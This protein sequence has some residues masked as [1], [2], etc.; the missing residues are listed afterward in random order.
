MQWAK[1]NVFQ[2]LTR[3]WDTIHPYNAAQA[4]RLAGALDAD[5]LVR[6]WESAMQSMGVGRVRFAGKWF[7]HEAPNGCAAPPPPVAASNLQTHVTAELNRPFHASFPLSPF[8]VADAN[9]PVVGVAY[10]HWIAD[11]A[12]IRVLLREWF[13]R[14]QDPSR[15]NST[16]GAFATDGYRRHVGPTFGR[17]DYFDSALTTLRWSMRL[18]KA[19][20]VESPQFAQLA[21]R[22][23]LHHLPNGIVHELLS[24]A[25][26][27]SATLND[28][29]LAVVAQVCNDLSPVKQT[30]RR[31]D[32]ALGTIVD[33]RSRDRA[34]LAD[35]FGLFLG[36]TSVVCRDREIGDW[37]SLLRTIAR[38]NVHH[39]RTAAAEASM[40]R[41]AAGLGLARIYSRQNLLNWYR[42][43]VPLAGG[44]S[45]VNM[46]R[47]WPAEF[48]PDPILEY[49][50]V[51]PCGP[52]MPLVFTTTTLGERLNFGLTCRRSVVPLELQHAIAGAFT[53]RLVEIARRGS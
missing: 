12:S 35:S 34:E 45:N 5:R 3:Q 23:T 51:S 31:P 24:V 43:R 27:G 47:D 42:K 29:F 18:R 38:Q 1:F 37:P 46:N 26:A 48:H 53:N 8:F 50:R 17:W 10:H 36:F 6:A 19:R 21:T 2:R 11:S 4:M 39:K 28:L 44:I 41:M 25:R 13:L 32:L 33:L 40:L 20:R 30:P 7:R 49:I 15:A 9:S 52:M 16:P 22:F 14:I